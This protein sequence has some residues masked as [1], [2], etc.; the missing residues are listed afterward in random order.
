VADSFCPWNEGRWRLTGDPKGA[1]CVR[2]ADP[3]DL[4]LS[5]RELGAANLRGVS[6]SALAG[7]GRVRE[8]R[9]G[10]LREAAVAFGSDVAPWPAHG[11]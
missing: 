8:V 6:L 2:T 3:A 5:V 4:A 9:D 1:V 10:A 11:F 7:A